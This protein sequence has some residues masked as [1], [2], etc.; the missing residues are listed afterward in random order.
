MGGS[1]T[2]YLTTSG[3]STNKGTVRLYAYD[4]N[5]DVQ[6]GGTAGFYAQAVGGDSVLSAPAGSLNDGVIQT[7]MDNVT[8]Y[9]TSNMAAGS[10]VTLIEDSDSKLTWTAEQDKSDLTKWTVTI[11]YEGKP[12]KTVDVTVLQ[13]AIK[14]IDLSSYT[15]S[16][17]RGSTQTDTKLIITYEDDT[18]AE[19]PVTTGMIVD[20]NYNI[21]KNGTYSGLTISY[22]GETFENY[23]LKVVNVTGVNDYPAYPNSGSV[24]LDKTAT[25]LDFQNTG[26][27]RIQLSAS[28]LPAGGVDVVAGPFCQ[29]RLATVM[30]RN[31]RKLRFY[32]VDLGLV[33]RAVAYISLSH[34]GSAANVH[35]V[36]RRA[37]GVYLFAGHHVHAQRNAFIQLGRFN[38]RKHTVM[39]GEGE[40]VKTFFAIISRRHC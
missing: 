36:Q 19:M 8:V 39:I 30:L 11:K 32:G 9:T 29:R 10:E 20:G 27:A 38:G 23:T 6:T 40:K 22:A 31:V 26:L 28:G 33:C 24:K 5:A 7:V 15:G 17:E 12:L 34:A 4:K 18:T 21:N 14:N 37:G 35:D 3:V 13:K 16:A 1:T 2:Y 25:G